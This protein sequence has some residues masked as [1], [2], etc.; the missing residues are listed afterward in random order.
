MIFYNFAEIYVMEIFL[1]IVSA[2]LILVGLIGCVAP[3]L[4]GPVLGYIGIIVLHFTE[5]VD[6]STVE[7]VILGI[8]TLLT[9]LLDYFLPAWLTKQFGG[10][11]FGVIGSILGLIV[12]LFF[13]PVGIIIGPFIGA[14]AGEL[15]KTKDTRLALKS[16]IGSFIGF[17]LT[18][19]FKLAICGVFIWYYISKMT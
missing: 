6:F 5:K 7:L 13:P 16:G 14:V 2:L 8:A 11:K 1:Y 17:I 9:I 18:T 3:V 19:G 15:Y 10:S 12:G 4:P